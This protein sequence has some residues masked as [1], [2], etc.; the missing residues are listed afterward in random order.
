MN[1]V[2]SNK[3]KKVFLC[4]EMKILEHSKIDIILSP[5]FYW[6]RIFEIPVKT[7][8]QAKAV[9]PTLFEDLIPEIT[10]LSYQI[11]KLD[12]NKYLCFAYS[13]QKIYE[14]LKNSGVNLSLINGIY[15]AQNECKE[16]NQFKVNG[17]GFLYTQDNILVKVPT[18]I[19]NDKTDL[20]EFINKINLSSNKVEIK[21]YSNFLNTKQLGIVIFICIIITI[22]NFSKFFIFKSEIS[23]IEEKME[24]IKS[25]NNLPSSSIQLDS[26]ININKKIAQNEINKRDIL[27]YLLENKKLEI[28]N[29]SINNNILEVN[30][31][32]TDK[33]NIEDYISNKYKIVSSTVIGV[34]LNI[35]VQL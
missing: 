22:L 8:S 23:K 2:S 3:S 18:E 12:E 21:L 20:N 15:F 30:V 6:V 26:I 10:E 24:E 1:L 13:N 28:K 9:L 25:F 17:K 29:I 19:I 16:F 5:E 14:S 11:L 34:N 33:K 7:L 4:T 35:K 31:I 27:S 32:N